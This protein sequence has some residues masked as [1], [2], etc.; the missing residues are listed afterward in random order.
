MFIYII[1]GWFKSVGKWWI[2]SRVWRSNGSSTTTTFDAI[3]ALS[4]V[5]F[6]EV[7]SMD[8]GSKHETSSIHIHC[9]IGFLAT[10]HCHNCTHCILSALWYVISNNKHILYQEYFKWQLRISYIAI[11]LIIRVSIVEK[12]HSLA[13]ENPKVI[14]SVLIFEKPFSEVIFSRK[15][16]VLLIF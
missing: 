11:W 9:C 6:E 4:N 1:S 3:W 12:T 15:K 16:K 7:P 13:I 10:H 5:T 8:C 14:F 2:T